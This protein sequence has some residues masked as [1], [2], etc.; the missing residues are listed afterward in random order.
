MFPYIVMFSHFAIS[1]V[2]IFFVYRALI[3]WE[4]VKINNNQFLLGALALT[5]PTF[6]LTLVW[7]PAIAG[8][9]IGWAL[10]FFMQKSYIKDDKA[11]AVLVLKAAA[12]L[13]LVIFL[14]LTASAF[15]LK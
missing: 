9:I 1:L 2:V 10:L 3:G 5:V 8:V 7:I 11:N 6:A 13:I 4:K 14:T 12:I 15:I